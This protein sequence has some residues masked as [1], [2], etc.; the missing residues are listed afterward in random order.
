MET[1][2]RFELAA[3]MPSPPRRRVE[4]AVPWIKRS[5]FFLT[6]FGESQFDEAW[7]SPAG[8]FHMILLARNHGAARQATSRSIAI[9]SRGPGGLR[10]TVRRFK[11]AGS[12]SV[13]TSSGR[14]SIRPTRT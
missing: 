6:N 13:S 4:Q 9:G 3:G 7:R 8:N 1:I 11:E 5:Y 2:E 10:R 12:A 14:R